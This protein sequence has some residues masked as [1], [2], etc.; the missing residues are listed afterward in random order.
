MPWGAVPLRSRRPPFARAEEAAASGPL[1]RSPSLVEETVTGPNGAI[2]SRDISEVNDRLAMTEKRAIE[3]APDVWLLAGWGIAHSMAIRAAKAGSSSIRETAHAPRRR[4]A[5]NSRR[6]W[7]GGFEW[8]RSFSLTGTLR[9][10]RTAAWRTTVPSSGA[11]NG[12]DKNRAAGSG[13][14]PLAG[15][16]QGR[17]I[18]QFAVSIRPRAPMPSPTISASCQK[19]C[20][21]GVKLP[22]TRPAVHTM[23]R[24]KPSPSPVRRSRSCPTGRTAPTAWASI[25]PASGSSYPTLCAGLHLQHL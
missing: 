22:P 15:F 4:C 3:V 8:R 20:F 23:A 2:T 14:C 6:S 10:R 25:F 7:A 1:W 24:W 11:T 18:S 9:R 21:G 5:K 13:A 12:L 17:A 19:S 16:Y